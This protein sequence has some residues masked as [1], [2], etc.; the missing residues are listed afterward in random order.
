MEGGI[1]FGF[2]LEDLFAKGADPL[3]SFMTMGMQS[4]V[5]LNAWGDFSKVLIGL[6][7]GMTKGDSAK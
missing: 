6:F 5:A 3:A 2:S 7:E 4:M 1:K